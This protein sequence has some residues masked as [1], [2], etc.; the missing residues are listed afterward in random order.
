MR[1]WAWLIWVLLQ[2]V[3]CSGSGPSGWVFVR[4][5]RIIDGRRQQFGGGHNQGA[6]LKTCRKVGDGLMISAAGSQSQLPVVLPGIASTTR[7][8]RWYFQT[9]QPILH[10]YVRI[11]LRDC[12]WLYRPGT[13]HLGAC[14]VRGGSIG[15]RVGFGVQRR[16][17]IE[18]LIQEQ[19]RELMLSGWLTFCG[20]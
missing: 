9:V 13:A 2:L 11:R 10:L 15:R 19:V 6:V 12:D 3:T 1:W 17:L 7:R 8:S 18:L 20:Q 16:R 4:G 5:W 14:R